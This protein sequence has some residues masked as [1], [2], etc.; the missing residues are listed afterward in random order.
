MKGNDNIST[1]TTSEIVLHSP[2][3][4]KINI[5]HAVNSHYGTK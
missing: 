1:Y 3:N 5:K 2:Y 4:L